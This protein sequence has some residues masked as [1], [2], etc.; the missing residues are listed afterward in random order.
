MRIHTFV[1]SVGLS[2]AVAMAQ[3]PP[4]AQAFLPE[5]H[6][7]ILWADLAKLRARG[8]WEDIEASVLKLAF[9]EIEKEVGFALADLDRAT[10]VAE[11]PTGGMAAERRRIVIFEGHAPLP[12]P[13]R[14]TRAGYE[15]ETVGTHSV[16]RHGDDSTQVFVQVRPELQVMGHE[17]LI[18]PVLSGARAGGQPAADV[19]SLLSGRGV[20]LAGAVLS[21]ADPSMRRRVL[22]SVFADVKWPHGDEPTFLLLRLCAV[23]SD[24]DPHVEAHIVLRHRQPGGGLAVTEAVVE[25]LLPK[26]KKEGALVSVR[27][28]WPRLQKRCDHGDLCLSLDLGRTREA[29]G[30]LA[31]LVGTYLIARPSEVQAVQAAAAPVPEPPK[32]Q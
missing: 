20:N 13:D 2:F 14:I 4:T 26:L 10:M 24:D 27:P 32:K 30:H 29:I 19:L 16:H 23:G 3:Q 18:V 8:I 21:L 5:G 1:S 17:D 28:L 31:T 6:E 22:S 11:L 9:A 15:Q 25:A 7:N 12:I